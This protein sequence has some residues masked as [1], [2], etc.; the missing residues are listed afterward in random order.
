[1][2]TPPKPPSRTPSGAPAP[3]TAPDARELV[4]RA[5]RD[6]RQASA[7][8]A[9]LDLDQQVA[10][11]CEAP[12]AQ[13]GLLLELMPEPEA[14]IPRLPPAE[15][16]FTAKAMGRQEAG[17]LL[18]YATTEQLGAVFDLDAW[19]GIDP[20]PRALD[21]WLGAL[22][23]A[24]DQATLRAART[25][26][27]ELLVLHLRHKAA[28]H[29][30]PGDDPD[31]EP[32][33]GGETLDGQF[34][35]VARDAGDDLS[36][37]MRTLQTLFQED[38]WLYFRLL[39]GVIWELE[40]ELEEWARRWRTGRLEE[41]GF[42]AWEDAM[43]IY[44]FVREEERAHLPEQDRA[45]HFEDW[46]L[47]VW[48]PRLPAGLDGRLS[49]FRA[50]AE[51]GAEERRAFFYGFVAMANKVAVADRLPLGDAETLPNAIGKAAEVMSE[52]LDHIARATGRSE[53]EVLRRAGLERLYR[54]GASLDPARTH[55][56]PLPLDDD[57]PA[58]S[59]QP[60]DADP[61]P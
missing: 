58:E 57:E 31:W 35:L 15:L 2:T 10:A 30:K 59:A 20:D 33:D 25:V 34:Y 44:G 42:P 17:W 4:R 50:V 14:V 27:P 55:P 45:L 49:L 8:L 32:P 9:R 16:C 43:R 11:V 18:E 40:P 37:V 24:G 41:L 38:Y 13:R 5:Q 47:P 48:I 56:D 23:E 54:V 53:G 46:R 26:D 60:A 36:S 51:L 39:Q 7:D 1:M 29:L 22:V 6:R 19:S 28:V 52:G 12:V 3:G 21:T 61:L